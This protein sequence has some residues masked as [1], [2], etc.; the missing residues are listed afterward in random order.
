MEAF[1][2]IGGLIVIALIRNHNDSQRSDSSGLARFDGGNDDANRDHTDP[3]QRSLFDDGL[4]S[5]C[6]ASIGIDDTWS[7]FDDSSTSSFDQH[8]NIW[9]DPSYSWMDGNIFHHDSS[10]SSFDHS[11]S[12]CFDSHSSFS[13]SSS[14]FSDW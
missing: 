6:T 3:F 11:H 9:T 7:L 8:V 14:S 4:T 13:S 1:I 5:S 10:S 12:S 2:L